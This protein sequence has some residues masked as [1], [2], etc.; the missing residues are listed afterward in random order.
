MRY[1]KPMDDWKRC[2]ECGRFIDTLS[3]ECEHCNSTSTERVG[4]WASDY[5][6]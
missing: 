4:G 2:L 1:R 6:K 5:Y 3:S